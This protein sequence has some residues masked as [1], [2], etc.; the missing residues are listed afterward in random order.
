MVPTPLPGKAAPVTASSASAHGRA[1]SPQAAL[2]GKPMVDE[3]LFAEQRMRGVLLAPV[4]PHGAP[5]HV[6]SRQDFPCV[7]IDRAGTRTRC[8]QWPPTTFLAEANRRN[9]LSR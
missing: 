8:A 7:V 9:S 4:D 2:P 6:L 1:L 5:W 3:S